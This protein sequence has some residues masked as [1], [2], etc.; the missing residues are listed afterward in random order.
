MELR[1]RMFLTMAMVLLLRMFLTDFIEWRFVY[2]TPSA[3]EPELPMPRHIRM[4]SFNASDLPGMQQRFGGKRLSDAERLDA[5]EAAW[6]AEDVAREAAN[7]PEA[8]N[9]QQLNRVVH[10]E[11]HNLTVPQRDWHTQSKAARAADFWSSKTLLSPASPLLRKCV[12]VV[13]GTD[14]SGHAAAAILAQ[15]PPWRQPRGK[16]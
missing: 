1:T 2:D 9:E 13:G 12:M 15:S 3:P 10:H 16:S 8:A 14:G 11:Y 7:E 4:R 5:L 6:D